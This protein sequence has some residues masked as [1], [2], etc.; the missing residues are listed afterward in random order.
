[1]KEIKGGEQIAEVEII[2]GELVQFQLDE[3]GIF[4][5]KAKDK[6]ITPEFLEQYYQLIKSFLDHHGVKPPVIYNASEL[7]PIEGKIRK[8]LEVLLEEVFSALGVVSNSKMGYAIAYIFFGL[9]RSSFPKKIFKNREEAYQWLL[10]QK[11]FGP[12][13]YKNTLPLIQKFEF[14][15]GSKFS[16]LNGTPS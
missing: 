16:S 9:S 5:L 7:P 15:V 8:R 2:H 13:F 6:L 12:G 1:M 10:N 14:Q 11:W 3:N 4:H